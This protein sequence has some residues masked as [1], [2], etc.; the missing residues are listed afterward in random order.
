MGEYIKGLSNS[1]LDDEINPELK[2]YIEKEIFP[3]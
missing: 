3:L 2:V 1:K